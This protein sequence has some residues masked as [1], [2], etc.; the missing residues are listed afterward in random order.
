MEY[1]N[2]G[3]YW[4]FEERDYLK[5]EAKKGTSLEVISNTLLRSPIAV[6][7]EARVDS[8]IE[9]RSDRYVFKDDKTRPINEQRHSHGTNWDPSEDKML[10]QRFQEKHESVQSI[11]SAMGRTEKAIILRLLT[12]FGKKGIEELFDEC[13]EYYKLIRI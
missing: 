5:N 8:S 12:V 13:R 9:M 7:L 11:A 1:T 6:L 4:S 3:K 2:N 10:R